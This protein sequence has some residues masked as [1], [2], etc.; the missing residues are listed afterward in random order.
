MALGLV[1]VV[2]P[3]GAPGDYIFATAQL[4]NRYIA[5]MYAIFVPG[6]IMYIILYSSYDHKIIYSICTKF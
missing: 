2:V 5:T 4:G 6:Q 3:V 1:E